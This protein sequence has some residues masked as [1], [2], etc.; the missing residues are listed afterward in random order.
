MSASIPLSLS[1]SLARLLS[2]GRLQ[3]RK[4]MHTNSRKRGQWIRTKK[5]QVIWKSSSSSLSL[6]LPSVQNEHEYMPHTGKSTCYYGYIAR[7]H[8]AFCIIIISIVAAAAASSSTTAFSSSSA[9]SSSSSFSSSSRAVYP[10][11]DGNDTEKR[12]EEERE[13]WRIGKKRMKGVSASLFFLLL[14]LLLLV[15]S[16]LFPKK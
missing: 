9:P 1:R 13:R 2:L 8:D 5:K 16:A 7:A 10:R 4:H 3:M 15:G 12:W 11:N 6:L 14:L